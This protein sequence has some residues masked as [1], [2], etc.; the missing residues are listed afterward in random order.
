MSYNTRLGFFPCKELVSLVCCS[1]GLK[2]SG[3]EGFKALYNTKK[4]EGKFHDY[5]SQH[6]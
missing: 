3:L 4:L 1:Q 2:R 6:T 5:D